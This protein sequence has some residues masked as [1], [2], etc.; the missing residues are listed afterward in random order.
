MEEVN[1]A[2]LNTVVLSAALIVGL[3]FGAVS[4]KTHFCT[5]GAVADAINFQDWSRVRMWVLSI[6]VATLGFQGLVQLGIANPQD[7]IYLSPV[8]SWLSAL[9]GGLLFGIGMVL[10]SGCGSKTLIRLGAGNLKALYVFVVL[11]LAAFMTLKGITGV[12]RVNVFDPITVDLGSTVYI[13]DM[14]K[15]G[16]TV[17]VIVRFAIP[18]A[19]IAWVFSKRSGFSKDVLLG[20]LGVGLCAVAAWYIT[21]GIAHLAEHPDTLEPAFIGSYT[22]GKAEAMSFVAPYAQTLEWLIFFSDFSR[23]LTLGIVYCAGVIFG[24]LVMALADGSFRWE[25]FNG[26]EDMANHTVGAVMMGVGGVMAMGCTVGQGLSGVSTLSLTSWIT[27]GFI[28][29]GA[30]LGLRYQMWRIERMV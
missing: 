24:S 4:Q 6:G 26:V 5:M 16:E 13:P 29:V 17:S 27:L 30:V 11:G 9:I 22:S 7:T 28:V 15:G 25:S 1:I 18:A 19:L 14:F 10:A 8:W 21:F 3:I 12:L 20:G 2:Q 23:V